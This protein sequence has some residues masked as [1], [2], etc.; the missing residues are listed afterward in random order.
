[1]VFPSFAD[2]VTGDDAMRPDPDGVVGVPG[3]FMAISPTASL[4]TKLSI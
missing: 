2:P 1:M 3:I 4:I